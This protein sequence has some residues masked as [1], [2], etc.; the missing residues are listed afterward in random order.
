VGTILKEREVSGTIL[1]VRSRTFK[2]LANSS[3]RKYHPNMKVGTTKN[4]ALKREESARISLVSEGPGNP[5]GET[6]TEES[7]SYGCLKIT[8]SNDIT[9]PLCCVRGSL[10][11]IHAAANGR[12]LYGISNGDPT[13]NPKSKKK[14]PEPERRCKD[15]STPQSSHKVNR[16]TMPEPSKG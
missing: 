4:N 7:I 2:L 11:N 16:E 3:L 14:T 5:K 8:S 10:V 12:K 9:P 6:K 13:S 15:T 1:N